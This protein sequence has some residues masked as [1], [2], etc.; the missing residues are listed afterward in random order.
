[1]NTCYADSFQIFKKG[2]EV[3][4]EASDFD[5]LSVRVLDL[6]DNSKRK[7]TPVKDY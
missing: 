7:E 1:M 4:E 2:K 6:K 3:K 5:T